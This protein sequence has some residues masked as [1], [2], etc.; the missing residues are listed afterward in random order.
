M[1]MPVRRSLSQDPA[2]DE[3]LIAATRDRVADRATN[4]S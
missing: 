1:T 3:N 4:R 2:P